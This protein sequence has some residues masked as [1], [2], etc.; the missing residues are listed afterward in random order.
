MI[1][2]KHSFQ[3][4]YTHD[5]YYYKTSFSIVLTYV[6]ISHKSQGAWTIAIKVIIDI[7]EIFAP[8]LT[9][10]MLSRIKNW[11]NL[12][13]SIIGN[14]ILNDFTH[15]NFLKLKLQQ[16]YFKIENLMEQMNEGSLRCTTT[17]L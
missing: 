11:N 14:L 10:V 7:K 9:Y 5:G 4:K 12:K 13:I 2:K 1:L 6:M 15:C 3:H 8:S 16:Y 17:I